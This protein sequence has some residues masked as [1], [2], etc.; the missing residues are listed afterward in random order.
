[1][2]LSEQVIKSQLTVASSDA[3]ACPDKSPN[4]WCSSVPDPLMDDVPASETPSCSRAS[5]SR[6]TASKLP[7]AFSSKSTSST[8]R[9]FPKPDAAR[10]LLPS[11]YS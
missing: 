2:Q 3:W 8:T 6:T 1:M 11:T 10:R 7:I 5:P 4:V 9:S